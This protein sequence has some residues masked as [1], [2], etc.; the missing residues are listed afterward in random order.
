MAHSCLRLVTLVF[1]L[2]EFWN[3][4]AKNVHSF[5]SPGAFVV[6]KRRLASDHADVCRRQFHDRRVIEARKVARYGLVCSDQV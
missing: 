4:V 3:F 2:C 6:C 5:V 1:K